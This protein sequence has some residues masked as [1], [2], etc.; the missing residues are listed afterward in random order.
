MLP[1]I[2]LLLGIQLLFIPFR[3]ETRKTTHVSK[4]PEK[5]LIQNQTFIISE[6][7]PSTNLTQSF[8]T[9][10]PTPDSTNKSLWVPLNHSPKSGLRDENKENPDSDSNITGKEDK[11]KRRMEGTFFGDDMV[12]KLRLLERKI[13]K[14]LERVD[15]AFPLYKLPIK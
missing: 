8:N 5:L 4:I 6:V 14:E 12:D 1:D 3:I 15:F 9:S 13:T 10:R 11:S 2:D 7:Y